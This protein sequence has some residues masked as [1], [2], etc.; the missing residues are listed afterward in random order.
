MPPPSA[1]QPKLA[2]GLLTRRLSPPAGSAAPAE[3]VD[4]AIVTMPLCP[5]GW[6][7]PLAMS[8]HHYRAGRFGVCLQ[9]GD[10]GRPAQFD[11]IEFFP[12]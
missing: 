1:T 7:V 2:V 4:A 10:E 9:Q 8:G 12:R 6:F 3:V 5:N 11:L